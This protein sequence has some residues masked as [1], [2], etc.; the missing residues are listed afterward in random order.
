MDVDAELRCGES[1]VAVHVEDEVLKAGVGVGLYGSVAGILHSN[2]GIA[3]H[4]LK[5]AEVSALGY[6][7]P[8]HSDHISVNNHSITAIDYQV[9]F[10]AAVLHCACGI[11]ELERVSCL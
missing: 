7:E 11:C 4:I 2:V 3:E 9:G 8:H 10:V 6:H 1:V 5:V